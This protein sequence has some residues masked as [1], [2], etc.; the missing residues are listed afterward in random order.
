MANLSKIGRGTTIVGNVRGAGHL[1]VE[2]R[3]EGTI[4]VDGDVTLSD[5][6]RVK[7]PVKGGRVAVRGAVLGD[8]SAR[9]SIVLEEGA[10]VVGDLSAPSIGI[11]P[12]GLLRGHVSTDP[13]LASSAPKAGRAVAP[14]VET[15]KATPQARPSSAG[16][17]PARV[18][19]EERPEAPRKEE[20]RKED[21]KRAF[22]EPA[23]SPLTKGKTREAPAPV[24]PA[25]QKGAKGA[26]KK[27]GA[28]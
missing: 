2:G 22:V 5:G 4:D 21:A 9:E 25:L 18:A 16:N 6:A 14:R 28:R 8:I 13:S 7:S 19:R 1:D 10:R 26:L 11:R 17:A 12:G 23:P 3:I 27:K 24:M 20:P 15:P